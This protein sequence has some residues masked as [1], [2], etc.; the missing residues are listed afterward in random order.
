MDVT[1]IADST[2]DG[3]TPVTAQLVGGC[4]NRRNPNVSPG[5]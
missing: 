4:F 3:L 2:D 5:E 1:V